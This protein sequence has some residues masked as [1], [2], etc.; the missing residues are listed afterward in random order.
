MSSGLVLTEQATPATP[1]SG[2]LKLYAKN[3]S[4]LYILDDA[5]S[6]TQIPVSTSYLPLSG[7]TLSG[8]LTIGATQGQFFDFVAS[9][10]ALSRNNYDANNYFRSY[11]TAGSNTTESYFDATHYWK[12]YADANNCYV[13]YINGSDKSIAINTNSG[14][15]VL[16][17]WKASAAAS[18]LEATIIAGSGQTGFLALNDATHSGLLYATSSLSAMYLAQGSASAGMD[19]GSTDAGIDLAF[20]TSLMAVSVNATDSTL[21]LTASGNSILLDPNG[22]SNFDGSVSI[23]GD[24]AVLGATTT[25]NTTNLLVED[26]L[27]LFASG[28]TTDAID[29]GLIGQR[30]S[31][32]IGL[33][34]DESAD[35]FAFILTTDDGTT[36]G[37]VTI[38]SY[39]DLRAGTIYGTLGTA[40]QPNITSVGTLTGLTISG[41]IIGVG[42]TT[43]T[44]GSGNSETLTLTSTSAGVLG[45][46][47]VNAADL[48]FNS[49]VPDFIMVDTNATTETEVQA[50]IIAGFTTGSS[51]WAWSIG[52]ETT[53][54]AH[55]SIRNR[56]AGGNVEIIGSG[57]GAIFDILLDTAVTGTLTVTG[58]LVVNTSA[59]FVDV[60]QNNVGIGTASPVSANRLQVAPMTDTGNDKIA[61]F[62]KA[63]GGGSGGLLFRNVS[64]IP[65]ITGAD[66]AGYVGAH[67]W[68]LQRT[69]TFLK[70][71][72]TG[73][74][75]TG[76]L[77]VSGNHT[78]G[79]GASASEL[80][81]LE[82]SAG[83]TSYTG[84]KAPALA[85]NVIYTLPTADGASGEVLSTNGSGALSWTAGGGGG[86]SNPCQSNGH[87]SEQTG[88]TSAVDTD[89]WVRWICPFDFTA[90][91][92][93]FFIINAGTDT[94]HLGVYDD[95]GNKLQATSKSVTT[96]TGIQSATITSQALT[97][98]SAYWLCL[99]TEVNAATLAGHDNGGSHV[100]IARA[101]YD[102]ASS[103]P[104][105]YAGSTVSSVIPW[106]G[107]CG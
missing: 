94:I 6:E 59:L 65:T 52:T 40:A 80:R 29:I 10:Y 15:N 17:N 57:G 95:S 61:Y 43:I 82:P 64:G 105:T 48:I 56:E 3:D 53:T 50:L 23:A 28:N 92:M 77:S 79:G 44:G 14:G 20:G 33:I 18:T 54:D 22:T 84:F 27:T 98:G 46:V 31:S 2:R 47:I 99:K 1:A 16:G 76:A 5:G 8:S 68:Q 89:Y 26:P 96:E 13:N 45:N 37:N 51:D 86:L 41:D 60:S 12:A 9:G 4:L 36:S 81:L 66:D 104:A 32:N 58:D 11:L 30:L 7:G 21:T 62:G 73:V 71:T 72:T 90:T 38:S 91:S 103:L 67:D 83:G 35:E 70:L 75:I 42:G 63:S 55:V 101:L 102:V 106:V 97:G 88:F 107:I 25:I 49:A 78:I 19:V 100:Q 34:W 87:I 24:L 93:N 69:T 74:E 39:A 85:G